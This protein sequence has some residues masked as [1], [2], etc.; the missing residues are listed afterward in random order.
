[1][2]VEYKGLL[3]GQESDIGTVSGP[4]KSSIVILGLPMCQ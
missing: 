3:V 1:M 4:V 2:P